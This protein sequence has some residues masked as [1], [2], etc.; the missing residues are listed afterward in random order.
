MSSTLFPQIINPIRTS[1]F[2]RV[3]SLHW[4]NISAEKTHDCLKSLD[5]FC[6]LARYIFY[7]HAVELNIGLEIL[8]TILR[9]NYKLLEATI[10]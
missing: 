2:L 3:V 7:L 1:S 6:I 5:V 4:L 10:T 9:S 8:L